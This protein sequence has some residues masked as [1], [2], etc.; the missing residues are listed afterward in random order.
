M[1]RSSHTR[2][3]AESISRVVKSF[4]DE[5]VTSE[6][7]MNSAVEIMDWADSTNA[8][9][10]SEDLIW[11]VGRELFVILIEIEE[12]RWNHVRDRT[13]LD[14]ILQQLALGE[15]EWRRRARAGVWPP[16]KA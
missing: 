9:D 7:F 10:P 11:W 2:H 13:F 3:T 6:E 15:A 8:D 4:R 14:D 12:G 16:H 5:Q 1:T